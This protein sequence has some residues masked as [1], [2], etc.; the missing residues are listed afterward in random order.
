[1]YRY[2]SRV[3]DK[4]ETPRLNL[5][6]W[7]LSVQWQTSSCSTLPTSN[8]PHLEGVFHKLSK[9]GSNPVGLAKTALPTGELNPTLVQ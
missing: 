2:D 1:M 8:V 7:F 9:Q 4:I 5:Y 3:Q 6:T